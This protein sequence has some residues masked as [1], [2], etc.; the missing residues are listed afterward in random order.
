M[1]DGKHLTDCRAE[2]A[3]TAA[4]NLASAKVAPSTTSARP[5]AAPPL[6]PVWSSATANAATLRSLPHR[7]SPASLPNSGHR[8]CYSRPVKPIPVA[9]RSARRILGQSVV[10]LEDAP[11]MTR[12]RGLRRRYRLPASA[13][14]A[15]RALGLCEC[16][17]AVRKR[18]R[19]TGRADSRR[20][21][22]RGGH[23]RPAADRFSRSLST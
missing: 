10:R 22:D 6:G 2:F 14:Y 23:R 20:G 8:V 15:H 11:L 7:A 21:V 1:G 4:P 13:A 18:G 9:S 17:A 3:P 16:R 12:A 5:R 19:C